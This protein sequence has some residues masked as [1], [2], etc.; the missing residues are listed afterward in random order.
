MAAATPPS[1][2]ADTPPSPAPASAKPAVKAA[3]PGPA[4]VR[5]WKV[6]ERTTVTLAGGQRVEFE[7]GK[8]LHAHH[9]GI[10]RIK[11]LKRGGLELDE[12]EPI[13]AADLES[14]RDDDV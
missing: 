4:P 13:A 1:T 7:K 3:P 2:P 6:K 10:P 14:A 11:E 9:Y 8:V 5:R 12:I